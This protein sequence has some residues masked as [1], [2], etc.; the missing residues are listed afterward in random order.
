MV[1][2][3]EKQRFWAR[4]AGL[5]QR[6]DRSP[7]LIAAA[8]RARQMLPGDAEFGDSLSTAGTKQ[9]HVLGRQLSLMTAERPGVLRE[10]GLSALQVWQALSEAQG[11]GRGTDE[12]T[13]VFTDLVDFS[14]WALEAGDDAALRLLR[15]LDDIVQPA[16]HRAG[17]EVV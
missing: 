1:E 7:S 2:S 9:P 17:G 4:V 6:V 3:A 12:V 5:V 14:E 10:T 11:R 16:T 13:I 8:R 15:C